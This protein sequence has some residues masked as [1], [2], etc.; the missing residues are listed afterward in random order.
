MPSIEEEAGA[1]AKK[2]DGEL[3]FER[4]QCEYTRIAEER[5][6]KL[7]YDARAVF[8]AMDGWGEVQTQED[9]QA[10]VAKANI[11][12]ERTNKRIFSFISMR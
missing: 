2:E 5:N 6:L 1:L 3:D 4:F 8:R 9:W 12:A 10:K 7:M 11:I